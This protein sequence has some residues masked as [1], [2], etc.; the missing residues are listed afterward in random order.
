MNDI[1]ARLNSGC[2]ACCRWWFGKSGSLCWFWSHMLT[3][4][5]HN[6]FCLSHWQRFCLKSMKKKKRKP[7]E[8]LDPAVYLYF[9]GSKDLRTWPGSN[10]GY[11]LCCRCRICVCLPCAQVSQHYDS[12]VLIHEKHICEIGGLLRELRLTE[13]GF[14]FCVQHT[15]AH[16]WVWLPGC[17]CVY[18]CFPCRSVWLQPQSSRFFSHYLWLWV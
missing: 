12:S 5:W 9:R 3:L 4:S 2:V 16:I 6:P 17:V 11:D 18:V 10:P 8:L 14:P 1:P 15:H 13:R 7:K